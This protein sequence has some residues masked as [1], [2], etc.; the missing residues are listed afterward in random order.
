MRGHAL[1]PIWEERCSKYKLFVQ[2][3]HCGVI[4]YLWWRA[5][6]RAEGNNAEGEKDE[7]WR[8]GRGKWEVEERRNS[9]EKWILENTKRHRDHKQAAE[10]E[11]GAGRSCPP[12]GT[13]KGLVSITAPSAFMI[14]CFWRSISPQWKSIGILKKLISRNGENDSLSNSHWIGKGNRVSTWAT[15]RESRTNAQIFPSF[16]GDSWCMRIL[17]KLPM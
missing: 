8:K 13:H 3:T 12:A 7:A 10:V 2:V 14:N 15:T 9:L 17:W 4:T 1:S 11:W 6:A 16:P 5:Q